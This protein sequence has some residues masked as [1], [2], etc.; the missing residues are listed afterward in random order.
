MASSS[1]LVSKMHIE[2]WSL[3]KKKL[4]YLN[5]FMLKWYYTHMLTFTP[6]NLKIKK[7]TTLYLLYMGTYK[8][9]LN[10]WQKRITEWKN[11]TLSASFYI[12]LNW[13]P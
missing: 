13:H 7:V 3:S 11:N 12:V 1:W 9:C 4:Q 6:Q 10:L 2:F 8:V 5:N